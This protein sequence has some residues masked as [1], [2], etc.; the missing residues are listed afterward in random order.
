M[1]SADP[2]GRELRDYLSVMRRRKGTIVLAIAVAVGMALLASFLQEKVYEARARVVLKPRQSLFQTAVVPQVDPTEVETEMQF[3]E[4]EPVRQAARERLGVVPKVSV[5][6]VGTTS[7]VEVKV[8]NTNPQE[9]SRLANG[10]VD[11][12][13][14]FRRKAITDELQASAK[15]LQVRVDDLQKRIDALAEELSQA[16]CTPTNAA[17]CGRRDALQKDRDTLLNQQA[18][19]KAKLDQFQLDSSLTNAGA[20]LI[21]PAPVPKTPVQPRPVRNALVA[22]GVGLVLGIGLA[23]L[24]DHLD[25]SLKSKEDLER[26]AQGLPVLGLIPAVGNWKN[27]TQTPVVSQAEPNSPTAEA[28]RTLRTSIQFSSIDRPMRI[29]TITSPSAAEGKT[30]TTANLAVALARAGQRVVVVGCDLRRPRIHEF[31][32]L[33]NH[34]GF[35]SVLLGEVPLSKALQQVP[36]ETGLRLMG[37][38]F[39]P[40]NP[41]ELLASNRADEVLRALAAQHDSV[42]LDCSPVLPVTDA[43][44]LS[45]KAHGTLLVATMGQTT[46]KQLFRAIELLRQVGAPLIGTVLNGVEPGG[47]Y[48]YYYYRRAE[49]PTNGSKPRSQKGPQ[50][51]TR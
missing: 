18:P 27:K 34:V 2:A 16:S 50:S 46:G 42:L 6:Q 45:S 31:F 11:A 41:S 26:V 1:V 8:R 36:G 22:A 13:I 39:L 23:L 35:T 12:Y 25:D 44:V 47:A 43:A 14:D 51:V 33:S 24:L 48:G 3:I 21:A 29:I 20:E 28:Y 38:G 30:T 17:G 49:A 7:V 4:S 5:N 15:E 37:S 40:P 19:L 32:G 10:Y 9:A